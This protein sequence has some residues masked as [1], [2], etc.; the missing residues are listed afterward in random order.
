MA[1]SD[2]TTLRYQTYPPTKND[3]SVVPSAT[4]W[5]NTAWTQILWPYGQPLF[6]WSL[7]C[8]I[9]NVVAT[10]VE[11]DVGI[12]AA[13]SET[14]IATFKAAVINGNAAMPPLLP[15]FVPYDLPAFTRVAFRARSEAN[16]AVNSVSVSLNFVEQA[17]TTAA[18]PRMGRHINRRYPQG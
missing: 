9:P 7:E 4:P 14:V 6:L 5:E 17:Q 16:D 11:I 13:G 12:G 15:F 1:Y 3:V 8:L 2:S 10:E 18:Q